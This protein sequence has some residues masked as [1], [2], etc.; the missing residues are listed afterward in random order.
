MEQ[1]RDGGKKYK[2]QVFRLKYKI[3]IA[4]LGVMSLTFQLKGLDYPT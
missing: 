4:M 3:S 1:K 2:K